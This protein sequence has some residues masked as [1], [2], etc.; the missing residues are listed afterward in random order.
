MGGAPLANPTAT[1]RA[2]TGGWRDSGGGGGGVLGFAWRGMLEDART[3]RVRGRVSVFA[4]G[5]VCVVL[6]V[7]V[8]LCVLEC[9]GV[10]SRG[11]D[12][13]NCGQGGG[14]QASQRC[15]NDI[16]GSVEPTNG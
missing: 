11:R 4:L 1:A 13:P 5:N 16:V 6:C 3:V 9:A 10:G 2:G 7:C 14:L 12:G 8:W 15:A